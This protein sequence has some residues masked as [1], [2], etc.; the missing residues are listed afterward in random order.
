[1]VERG[2]A[3]EVRGVIDRELEIRRL[4]RTRPRSR[5][6]RLSV[7]LLLGLIAYAW[8]GGGLAPREFFTERRA[9]NLDRF[10]TEITPYPLQGKPFDLGV[11]LAWAGERLRER[12]GEAA[13]LTLAISVAAIVL[14]GLAAGIL[15]PA[16]ARTVAT[17]EPYLPAST[18][19]H[20]A[21]RLAWMALIAAVRLLFILVRAI[22]EYVWAF[23]LVLLLGTSAWPAV[24]ALAIH[25]TGIL[26]RLGAETIE[27]LPPA[28]PAALRAL[29]ARRTQLLLFGI[30]PA[31]LGRSLLYFFYRWETCVRTATILG[32]LNILS[33]GFWVQQTRGANRYDE[34]F[35]LVL[36]GAALVLAGDLVSAV[37]RA[38][39]RRA[40]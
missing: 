10:L 37:A 33:L 22:P 12:D 28:T 23:L 15:G 9:R 38:L 14:A 21:V 39:V 30:Y 40:G 32:L 17:P 1:V 31:I 5:F 29:G 18:P 3:P 36:V 27:N 35:F 34:M 11:A 25:N 8:I 4:H 16:A 26:G 24:L 20:L 7:L 2:A 13:L 6:A 19:P